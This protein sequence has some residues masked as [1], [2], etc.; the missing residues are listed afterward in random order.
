M[1]LERIARGLRVEAAIQA[2]Q[3]RCTSEA[4]RVS[5]IRRAKAIH[6][7]FALRRQ[8][9]SF[10]GM[11]GPAGSQGSI[12]FAHD[13]LAVEVGGS[14]YTGRRGAGFSVRGKRRLRGAGVPG[15]RRARAKASRK[16]GRESSEDE[17]ESEQSSSEGE[18]NDSGDSEGRYE[19]RGQWRQC[20]RR[21]AATEQ[22]E[23]S[24][25]GS[26]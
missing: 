20:A 23:S 22:T 11:M 25:A 10:A 4:A 18:Y 26:G 16:R 5:L 12:G 14:G 9:E 3:K 7:K 2:C 13:G 19:D 6:R 17:S 1:I 8:Q 15:R 24:R 21:W